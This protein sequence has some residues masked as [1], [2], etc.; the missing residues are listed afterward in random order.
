MFCVEQRKTVAFLLATVQN[1]HKL[2]G[3]RR[4][5]LLPRKI[6][7][8]SGKLRQLQP[9]SVKKLIFQAEIFP[10]FRIHL[11]IAVFGVADEG[12]PD[13]GQMSA[14]LMGTAGNQIDLQIGIRLSVV[15]QLF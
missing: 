5:I 15:S 14:D 7:K 1:V 11:R 2:F 10:E 8:G 12:M 9:V 6:G 13:A 3:K 4:N